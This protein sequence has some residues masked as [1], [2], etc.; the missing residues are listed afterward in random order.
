MTCLDIVIDPVALRGDRWFLGR[1]YFYPGGG[2][3]FGVTIANFLGWFLVCFVILRV[4]IFVDRRLT[5]SAF[6]AGGRS[7]RIA[8]YGAVALYFGVLAF[9]L[10]MTFWIGETTLGL[11]GLG[12]TAVLAVTAGAAVEQSSWAYGAGR[13]RV[14]RIGSMKNETIERICVFCGS[15]SGRGDQYE[16]AAVEMARVM[17][18]G[19]IDM[20]YGGGRV[21][22]MGV[23]ADE[24]LRLGREV[25]GVIPRALADREVAH[26]G[27]TDLRIVRTMHERKS[28]DDGV[29][30]CIHCSTWGIWHAG[31]IVR[32]SD[33]GPTRDSREADWYY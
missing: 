31:R 32:G 22:L 23:M 11:I 7:D 26:T 21:G 13:Q 30:R 5:W 3:Y 15:S 6:A 9:N 14:M 1:L 18:S 25:I 20:V 2:R 12:L 29:V 27:L 28:L 33:V 16:A 19:G 24:M 17:A 4:F 10:T 8:T